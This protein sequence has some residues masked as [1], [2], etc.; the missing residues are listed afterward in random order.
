MKSCPLSLSRRRK[1]VYVHEHHDRSMSILTRSQPS[2][3]KTGV[4]PFSLLAP[5][6]PKPRM[7]P[8]PSTGRSRYST[9]SL[10][11]AHTITQPSSPI[12]LP[13]ALPSPIFKR[14]RSVDSLSTRGRGV[15]KSKWRGGNLQ[16]SHSNLRPKQGVIKKERRGRTP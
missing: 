6:P 4:E 12:P 7:P 9:F 1:R 10:G 2:V 8:P 15:Y 16:L 11:M 13:T 3:A 5:I 14:S